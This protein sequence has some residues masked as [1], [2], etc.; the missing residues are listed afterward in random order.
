MSKNETSIYAFKTL[1]IPRVTG[2][3]PALTPATKLEAF[4]QLLAKGYTAGEAMAKLEKEDGHKAKLPETPPAGISNDATRPTR[5]T[6]GHFEVLAHYFKT[7]I[8]NKWTV[9]KHISFALGLKKT[10]VQ[11]DLAAM[12][13]RKMIERR[14]L[15]SH[16]PYEF[17]EVQK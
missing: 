7:K 17:R 11:Y 9:S 2:P 3:R 5:K 10:H 13:D 6:G 8:K 4:R 16:G 12:A 15:S 1:V 14:K